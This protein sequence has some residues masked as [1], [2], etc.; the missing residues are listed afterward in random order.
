MA[1]KNTHHGLRAGEELIWHAAPCEGKDYGKIDRWLVP[2]S[3]L[4]LAFST[5]FAMSLIFSV[6]HTGFHLCHIVG[7]ILL[8]LIG[9]L[10]V[11][12]YFFRFIFKRRAK[13][14]LFYGLT[15][16]RRLLIC[17]QNSGRIYEFSPAQYKDAAITE[18]DRRGIGTIYL[19][20]KRFVHMLD[21]SGLDF[22][23]LKSGAHI[24]LYDIPKCKKVLKLLQGRW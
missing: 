6:V 23:G 16:E 9:G 17:D 24:A 14:D 11:Y 1:K 20:P 15:S 7:L 3:A 12:S 4:M 13:A 19:K 22:L 2:L 10:S 8:L 5:F 18:V 21:N